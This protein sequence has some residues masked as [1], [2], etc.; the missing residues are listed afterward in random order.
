MTPA[1]DR[2]PAHASRRRNPSAGA[3][4]GCNARRPSISTR[5]AGTGIGRISLSR[6]LSA[7]SAACSSN[8]TASPWPAIVICRVTSVARTGVLD[9]ALNDWQAAGLLKPSIARLDR[10][11]TA[12]KTVFLRRLGVLRAADLDAVR[13]TWNAHM[14]L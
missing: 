5:Y 2:R 7:C 4:A 12:E 13:N 14:T 3:A 6:P 9:V 10:L 8:S 1:G 11:V